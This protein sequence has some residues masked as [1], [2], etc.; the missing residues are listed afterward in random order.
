MFRKIPNFIM[1]LM[2][3][4]LVEYTIPLG[5]VAIGSIKAKLAATTTAK[6][7]YNISTL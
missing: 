2:F 7:G 1:V 4:N 5:G 6:T 3:I